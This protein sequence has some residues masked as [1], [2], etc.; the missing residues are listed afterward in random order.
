MN[1]VLLLALDE[2]VS[3]LLLLLYMFVGFFFLVLSFLR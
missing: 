2:V 1:E 3:L